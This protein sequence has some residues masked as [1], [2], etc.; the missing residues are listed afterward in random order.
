MK[1]DTWR[2]FTLVE[3]LVVVVIIGIL[4]SVVLSSV[5]QAREAGYAT[6]CKANLHNLANGIQT[7]S[8][9]HI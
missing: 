7:L 6:Q 5:R 1:R 9:I 2:G 4:T 3:M 8:L